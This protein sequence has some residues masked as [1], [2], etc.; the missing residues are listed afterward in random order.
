M[1][2]MR[3]F[4]AQS[5]IGGQRHD[6]GDGDDQHPAVDLAGA[7]DRVLE[8][9]HAVTVFAK[10][11]LRPERQHGE[12]HEV[13]DQRTQATPKACEPSVCASPRTTP[14]E[15]RTPDGA[16]AA[17]DHGPQAEDEA[18]GALGGIEGRAHRHQVAA[19]ATIG[20]AMAMARE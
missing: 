14:A 6:D 20:Q 16:H 8:R 7:G 11:A 12:E 19:T 4:S 5:G 10:R 15:Q 1:V 18:H 2:R 17:H 13:P 3:L 9:G